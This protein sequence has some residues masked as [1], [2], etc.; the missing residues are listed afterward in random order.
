MTF[1]LRTG[2]AAL[3]AAA[4]FATGAAAQGWTPPGPITLKISFAPGGGTDTQGRLIAAALEDR[5]GWT[6]I[7]ENVPGRGGLTLADDLRDDP[8]DGTVIAMAATETFGYSML[9]A[10]TGWPLSDFTPI[11]TTASFQ[12]GLVA[13]SSSGLAS[14]WFSRAIFR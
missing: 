7:P 6:I 12:M 1:S 11:V 5:L 4:T 10:Q 8:N 9:A 2:L 13:A 3:V 14:G